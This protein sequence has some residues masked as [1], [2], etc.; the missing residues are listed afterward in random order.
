MITKC[1]SCGTRIRWVALDG[2]VVPVEPHPEGDLILGG[3]A[4]VA[5]LEPH[6]TVPES[7]ER[8]RSHY[9]SCPKQLELLRQRTAGG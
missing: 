6:E 1:R 9:S 8:Y 3:N 2:R 5:V 4:S 7:V